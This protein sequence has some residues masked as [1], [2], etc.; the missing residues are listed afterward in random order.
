MELDTILEGDCSMLLPTL[1]KRSFD[2]I[3]VD[4]PYDIQQ[5]FHSNL[6]KRIREIGYEHKPIPV[7]AWFPICMAL[8]KETG[9]LFVSANNARYLWPHIEKGELEIP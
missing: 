5:Q 6:A 2:L 7:S 9:T 1:P 8:L 3:Y 4:P